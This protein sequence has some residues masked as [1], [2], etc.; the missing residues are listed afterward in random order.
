M[1]KD[2]EPLGESRGKGR[3]LRNLEV[4]EVR[5]IATITVVFC[6]GSGVCPPVGAFR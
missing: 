3:P 1:E 6:C 4:R 5:M 2:A